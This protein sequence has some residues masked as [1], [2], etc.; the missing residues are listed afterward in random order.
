MR[1]S[2][3]SLFSAK[4]QAPLFATESPRLE[5]LNEDELV[6]LLGRVRRGRNKYSDLHQRQGATA[7]PA[8]NERFAATTS[9]ERTLRKAEIFDDAVSRVARYV[10]RAARAN[11]TAV[12]DQRLADARKAAPKPK[13]KAAKRPTKTKRRP[14]NTR[15]SKSSKP[16]VSGKRVGATS[17]ANKRQQSSKDRRQS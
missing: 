13:S 4:E 1:A 8:S 10:S 11:A 16:I 7:V 2:E 12:K 5:K 17:A 3:I 15:S 9:N 14:S 6:E